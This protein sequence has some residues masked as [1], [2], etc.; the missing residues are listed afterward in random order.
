MPIL[1][2]ACD[3]CS[4]PVDQLETSSLPRHDRALPGRA[5]SLSSS[6][7]GQTTHEAH[8]GAVVAAAQSYSTVETRLTNA[9]H[10]QSAT[11]SMRFSRCPISLA[12]LAR[13]SPRAC[14]APLPSLHSMSSTTSRRIIRSHNHQIIRYH[15]SPRQASVIPAEVHLMEIRV[16]EQSLSAFRFAAFDLLHSHETVLLSNS[17]V[18]LDG[19]AASVSI[20]TKERT[21]LE[22]TSTRCFGY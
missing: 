17:P 20:L 5:L 6:A 18:L 9:L 7:S 8:R 1:L 21:R 16:Q 19:L 14:D 10:G 12:M 2:H 22:R 11:T 4:R 15:Y 3:S 13:P